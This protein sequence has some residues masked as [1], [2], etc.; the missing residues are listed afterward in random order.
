METT[1][2]IDKPLSIDEA[3]QGLIAPEQTEETVEATEE[4]TQVTEEETIEATDE[5]AEVEELTAESDEEE[6]EASDDVDEEIEMEA[7]AEDDVDNDYEEDAVQDDSLDTYAVKVNGQV[8]QVTL[9]ELKQGYSGQEYV[10]S[11]MQENAR[12]K[13]EVEALYSALQN[14]RQQIQQLYQQLQQ[15]EIGQAPQPPSKELFESDP[16]EYME[17]K[18]KYDEA[19]ESYDANIRKIQEVSQ[20]Q[21]QAEQRAKQAY[22]KEQMAQL[23]KVIPEFA[24][25]KKASQIK[26]SLLTNGNKYY[27]YTAEEIG[28]VVDHRA[29]QVLHDAIKYRELQAGKKKV[30]QKATKKVVKAGAKRVNDSA[31]KVR[32]KQMAKLKQTGNINDA[33]SL[34]LK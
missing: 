14:D 18:I 23:Q 13:K 2:T 11:G 25:S 34:L 21:S 24:D 28:E 10:Q 7:S 29:I 33:V 20:Q 4:Q 8:K 32:Q 31:N 9:D 3:V 22:L 17:Q 1:E 5:N 16:I 27:G 30:V 12:A 15:G 6:I 19:K 26:D